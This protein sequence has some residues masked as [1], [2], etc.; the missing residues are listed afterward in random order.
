MQLTMED[1]KTLVKIYFKRYSDSSKKEKSKILDDF[2]KYTG[3]NRSYASFLLRSLPKEINPSRKKK[4][5]RRRKKIY[6]ESVKNALEF[7]WPIMDYICSKRIAPILPEVID[8]LERFKE[9]K[10]DYQTKEKLKK[11][12]PATIDRL[13]KSARTLQNIKGR[14]HTKPGN[15]LKKQIPIRTFADWDEDEIGFFEA[16]LVGHEGGN[17]SGK[18]FHSFN[19]TDIFSAWTMTYI[20]RN[21]A[22]ESVNGAI[23]KMREEI[24][25]P[26]LGFDSDNGGEFINQ[27]NF[28]YFDNSEIIFTR[29][30]AYKKNDNCF[31][32][33][34]NNSVVRRNVGYLRYDTEE[35]WEVLQNLYKHLNLYNNYFLPVMKLKEKSRNGAKAFRAYDK[36]KT[37]YQRLMDFSQMSTDKK[38]K[39]KQ[40]YKSL[41][42]VALKKEINKLQEKL[43][44]LSKGKNE[45]RKI[46]LIKSRNPFVEKQKLHKLR[47]ICKP[48]WESRKKIGKFDE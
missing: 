11:I 1:K 20:L 25:F 21:K 23:I 28:D 44:E 26:L 4:R 5:R 17:S 32:E 24:P 10:L 29:S 6:N 45:N 18:F 2:I 39:L 43:I 42:L 19:A 8:N 15:F 41:N 31:I 3:F 47:E 14:S 35:E 48:F 36:A 13:L 22:Q 27:I 12:S 34:K 40:I 7:I 37:P 9:I 38:N 16:D 30:R 33:Q 46:N